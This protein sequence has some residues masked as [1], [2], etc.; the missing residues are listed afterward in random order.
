M[1]E[2]PNFFNRVKGFLK[3]VQIERKKVT[4][5]TKGELY[6]STAVVVTVTLGLSVI[7]GACDSVLGYLM[8]LLLQLS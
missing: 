7:L 1:E 8:Q 2:K 4:W 6:G 5:P 3:E